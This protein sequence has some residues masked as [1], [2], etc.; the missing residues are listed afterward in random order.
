MLITVTVS[1]V[2]GETQWACRGKSPLDTLA[3]LGR[4]DHEG[5]TVSVVIEY[6]AAEG[7]AE[8]QRLVTGVG[9]TRHHG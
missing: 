5:S 7:Y 8:L 9:D 3:F 2:D 1:G 4:V 6:D